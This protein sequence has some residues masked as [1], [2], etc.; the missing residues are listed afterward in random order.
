VIPTSIEFGERYTDDSGWS[1]KLVIET[2]GNNVDID[3]GGGQPISCTCEDLWWLAS[4]AL[5][6]REKLG[7]DQLVV[8][9]PSP[10]NGTPPHE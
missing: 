2:H 7:F 6:A 5:E 3:V 10:P 4:A 8:E 9:G 1:R